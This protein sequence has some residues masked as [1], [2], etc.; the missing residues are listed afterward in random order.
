MSEAETEPANGNGET[1]KKG[2]RKLYVGDDGVGVW[3]KGMEV[4]NIMLDGVCEYF[5][6]SSLAS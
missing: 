5:K 4:D 6:H 2:K 1:S 3:R